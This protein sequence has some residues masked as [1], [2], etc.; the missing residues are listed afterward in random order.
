MVT[1]YHNHM[2]TV[3]N[4]PGSSQ[5]G[6]GVKGGNYICSQC[7]VVANKVFTVQLEGREDCR[8]LDS[9]RFPNQT[10][11]LSDTFIFLPCNNLEFSIGVSGKGWPHLQLRVTERHR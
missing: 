4:F 1:V 10:S 6:G 11:D 7:C 2:Y 9:D 8:D 5:D 3:Y